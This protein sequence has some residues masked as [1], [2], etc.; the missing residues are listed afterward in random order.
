[1]LHR[2]APVI[3]SNASV[4]EWFISYQIEENTHVAAFMKYGPLATT[5]CD[6]T[7]G[8]KPVQELTRPAQR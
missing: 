6:S 4:T 3:R 7:Q 1:M 8:Y 5:D 2:Q